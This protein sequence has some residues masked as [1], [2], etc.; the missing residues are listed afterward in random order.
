VIF[1]GEGLH[2]ISKRWRR[3]SPHLRSGM[4]EDA[5]KFRVSE[6]TI[7]YRTVIGRAGFPVLPMKARRFREATSHSPYRARLRMSA[8]WVWAH[9]PPRAVAT[10]RAFSVSAIFR[11]LAPSARNGRMSGKTFAAN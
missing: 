9:F 8:T 2:P 5:L 6:L 1:V 11:R 4:R 3:I 10:P 7:G